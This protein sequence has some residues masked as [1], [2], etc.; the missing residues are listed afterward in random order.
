MP[1]LLHGNIRFRRH[2]VACFR[3]QRR[4][5]SPDKSSVRRQDFLISRL[6][7]TTPD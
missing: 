7:P 1:I 3:V 4:S 5:E 2:W 6:G